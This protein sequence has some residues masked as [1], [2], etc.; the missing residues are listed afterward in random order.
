[1]QFLCVSSHV[2]DT[3]NYRKIRKKDQSSEFTIIN[4]EMAQKSHRSG[5]FIDLRQNAPNS[6]RR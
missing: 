1:M 5:A 2:A 3:G 4:G 6:T